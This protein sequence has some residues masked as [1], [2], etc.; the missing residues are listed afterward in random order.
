MLLASCTSG[1]GTGGKTGPDSNVDVDTPHLRVIK[2]EARIAH[3]R[4]AT[5]GK[6]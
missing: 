2:A 6:P 1:G 5:R 3:D 4:P